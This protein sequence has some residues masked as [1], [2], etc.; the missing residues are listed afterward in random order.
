M[1][2]FD[3]WSLQTPYTKHW[4]WLYVL[5]ALIPFLIV[6][7]IT[8]YVLS[9]LMTDEDLYYKEK[10]FSNRYTYSTLS[11][12]FSQIHLV[13]QIVPHFILADEDDKYMPFQFVNN[14]YFK[15]VTYSQGETSKEARFEE[16]YHYARDTNGNLPPL[17]FT[18]QV[19]PV[20]DSKSSCLH[21]A[22]RSKNAPLVPFEKYTPLSNLPKCFGQR[23]EIWNSDD[24][25]VGANLLVWKEFGNEHPGKC[26]NGI[27][28]NNICFEYAV[29]TKV[30]II[31]QPVNR[32][33]TQGWEIKEGC[34]EGGSTIEYK[35]A[36]PN[37]TYKF[38]DIPIE[39]WV[40][41]GPFYEFESSTTQFG[42]DLSYF[43]WL[44]RM[45]WVL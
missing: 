35:K 21:L 7:A 19:V 16:L 44:S 5:I 33:P 40:H 4:G 37:Q 32:D 36:K 20:G 38:D 27:I 29:M 1:A 18:S 24:P 6:L 41:K 8:F 31:I 28:K 3:P 23:Q 30:C 22:Y 9:L 42:A 45:C 10:Q 26:D 15:N 14:T 17:S 39:I 2:A 34:F 13:G 43:G 11:Y 25:V 12:E